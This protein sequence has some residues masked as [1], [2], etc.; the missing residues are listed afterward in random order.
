LNPDL[1]VHTD[2][3]TAWSAT[4]EIVILAYRLQRRTEETSWTS[5]I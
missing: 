5:A 2:V 4:D 1:V 3:T